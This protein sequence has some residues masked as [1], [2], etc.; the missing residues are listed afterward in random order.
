MLMLLKRITEMTEW[1]HLFSLAKRAVSAFT[2][3]V[4][5]S[6]LLWE[7]SHLDPSLCQVDFHSQ[8]FPREHVWI[9]RLCKNR[10]QSLQ[11]WKD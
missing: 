1:L 5:A 3:C 2:C 8:L 9:V 6:G 7:D 10:L 4:C 11:L